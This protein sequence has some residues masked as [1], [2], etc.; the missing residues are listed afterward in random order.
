MKNTLDRLGRRAAFWGGGALVVHY[1]L[2]LAHGLQ[3]G[4]VL[5]DAMHT[6][7]GR[8]DGVLFA[9]A[10][11]AIDVALLAGVFPDLRGGGS[12]AVK[13]LGRAGAGFAGLALPA[14]ML[15]LAGFLAGRMIPF[16]FPVACL[17]MFIGALLLGIAALC[18]RTLPRWAALTLIAFALGT[19]PL[20]FALPALMGGL[21]SYV[22]FEL[23][24][25]APGLAWLALASSLR[26][27]NSPAAPVSARS[28][29]HA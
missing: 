1:D 6:P 15:G 28:I 16:A 13:W 23:H 26:P 2:H 4:Q 29:A 18:A 25:V 11:G 20:G 24:F 14:A 21:P 7:L 19:A 8:I 27:K 9:T 12:S 3:T 22:S 5:W 10:F 17:S